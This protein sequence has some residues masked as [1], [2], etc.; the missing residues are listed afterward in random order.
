MPF[1]H[2]KQKLNFEEKKTESVQLSNCL[3]K[4]DLRIIRGKARLGRD[5]K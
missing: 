5:E 2:L 4:A 3:A 1:L